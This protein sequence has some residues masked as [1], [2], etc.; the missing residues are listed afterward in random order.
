MFYDKVYSHPE[1]PET[2]VIESDSQLDAWLANQQA[3]VR[4]S[5]NQSKGSSSGRSRKEVF[6]PIA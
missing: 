2:D 3:Q 5:K 4:A 1:R 6:T